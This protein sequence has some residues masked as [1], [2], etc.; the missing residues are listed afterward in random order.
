M[1]SNRVDEDY[2]SLGQAAEPSAVLLHFSEL[3]G[4]ERFVL[5]SARRRNRGAQAALQNEAEGM[6]KQNVNG[7]S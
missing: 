3:F 5:G 6:L 1:F 7:T 4:R 2:F